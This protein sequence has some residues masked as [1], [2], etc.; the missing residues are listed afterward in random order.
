MIENASESRD[1]AELTSATGSR[2]KATAVGPL[3][4]LDV[5]TKSG[6]TTRIALDKE[7]AASLAG[8]ILQLTR[9]HIG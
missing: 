5:T 1:T 6:V 2:V 4:M 7:T 8:V 3:I 9:L